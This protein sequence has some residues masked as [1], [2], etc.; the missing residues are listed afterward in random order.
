ML[1][2]GASME[3]IRTLMVPITGKIYFGEKAER[4]DHKNTEDVLGS[5]KGII[6]KLQRE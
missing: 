6:Y 1:V 2:S 5:L 3:S 4:S